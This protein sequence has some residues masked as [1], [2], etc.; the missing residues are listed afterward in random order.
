MPPPQQQL[1]A[2]YKRLLGEEFGIL[3]NRLYT[4]T[5]MPIQR[6]GA[7]LL[8]RGEFESYMNLLKNSYRPENLDAVMCR[9]LV[10]VDYQGHL[11]D[12]DF[13]QMLDIPLGGASGKRHLRDL[14]ELDHVPAEIG[15]ADHC[16]G[17][18]AGQ[19]SSC[20]GALSA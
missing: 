19:G 5:N 7:I 9:D 13:N 20:S 10:S 15:I 6:F 18:T 14:L 16:D 11:H 8:A 17:C 2:D 12:C 3:F 1:E 4:I